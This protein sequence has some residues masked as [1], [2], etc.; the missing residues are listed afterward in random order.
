MWNFASL[1][2]F[3]NADSCAT[4]IVSPL[5]TFQTMTTINSLFDFATSVLLNLERQ[6]FNYMRIAIFIVMAW[7]GGLKVCQY[8]ADGIVHFVANSPVMS[9][10][11]KNADNIVEHPKTGKMVKEYT[12]Y[13]NKEGEMVQKNIAWHEAN[14]TYVF[15]YGLGAAICAIGLLTLLGIW[16]PRLGMIGGLLTFGMSLV[17]LSFLITTPE[18]WV[19]NLGGDLPTPHHGFPY[20][21]AAGRLVIKDI[22]M[23]AG[24]LLVAMEAARRW[25][26]RKA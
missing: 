10:M 5:K 26:N 22:I 13:K 14:G 1:M 25:R 24:G 20:L 9:F 4:A 15:A 23:S 16:S 21:S 18:T 17:T 6:L 2:K 12:L 19:P 7:I 3:D 8:E 11:M